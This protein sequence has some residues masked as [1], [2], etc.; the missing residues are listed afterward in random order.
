MLLDN[1]CAPEASTSDGPDTQYWSAIW[2]TSVQPKVRVFLWRACRGI[3]PTQTNLFNKGISHTFSCL[4]CGEE[5]ETVDHLLWG[6][7]FAQKV[8]K[9]C[10]AQIPSSVTVSQSFSELVAQCMVTLNSLSLEIVLTI[11]WAIWKARN[12]LVWNDHLSPVVEICEQATGS[13][14]DNLESSVSL[15]LVHPW[16][17]APDSVKWLPPVRQN[18]K[19]NLSCAYNLGTSNSDVG[20][21]VRDFMGLVGVTRCS[22]IT[23][24]GTVLQIYA[25]SILNALE[26]VFYVGFR[27]LEVELENK[28]LL[29]LIQKAFSSPCLAPIGV[30]VDDIFAWAHGF[31]FLSFSF[32]LKYC[33]KATQALA[34]EAL[35]SSLDQVWLEDYP[36]CITSIVQF[37]SI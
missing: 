19:M 33:N 23:R 32:I 9:A 28:E 6:C 8:W 31:Q 24:D 10:P 29:G 7:D 1:H 34:T 18:F 36:D 4:W 2:S 13:T 30:V 26:F 5:A 21:I 20:V 25:H 12:D 3:L 15:A 37:D 17:D 27:R 11:A 35:S 16:I 14:L 22:R